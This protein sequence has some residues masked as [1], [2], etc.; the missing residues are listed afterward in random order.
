MWPV[1]LGAVGSTSGMTPDEV[2]MAAA[3]AAV[4]A[5]AW[6]ATRLLGA[7]PFAVARCLAD[8]VP[9]IDQEA[10][11]ACRLGAEASAAGGPGLISL[12]AYS[13]PL[14]EIGA[15]AH[16]AWEVRLFAS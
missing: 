11:D 8:L 16:A 1:A 12:P 6:A 4:T 7:D 5:P 15:E 9:T 2:A 10:S 14:L 13:G 3:H